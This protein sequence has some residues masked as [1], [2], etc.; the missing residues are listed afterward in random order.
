MPDQQ[1]SALPAQFAPLTCFKPAARRTAKAKL[2]VS[3]LRGWC[4]CGAF[5][6]SPSRPL[7][8]ISDHKITSA[9]MRA[10]L[11]EKDQKP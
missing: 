4:W 10:V 11:T 6:A 7:E 8:S 3:V 1:N 5:F 9:G 2:R